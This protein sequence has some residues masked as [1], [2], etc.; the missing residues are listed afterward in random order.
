MD[1][2]NIALPV[3]QIQSGSIAIVIRPPG[4]SPGYPGLQDIRFPDLPREKTPVNDCQYQPGPGLGRY[5][6]IPA[7]NSNDGPHLQK[8]D[9]IS[10]IS[11]S[12]RLINIDPNLIAQLR[13]SSNNW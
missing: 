5:C 2:A 13:R 4:N 3:D 11:E 10:Q 6:A 8:N 9:L 1:I 7:V 12:E